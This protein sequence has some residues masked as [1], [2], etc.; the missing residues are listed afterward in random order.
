M[1]Q[2][3]NHKKI[4]GA[5][6]H[7]GLKEA[8]GRQRGDGRAFFTAQNSMLCWRPGTSDVCLVAWPDE[9]SLAKGYMTTLACNSEF[10]KMSFEQRKA[11]VFIESMHL[12]IRDKVDP[13]AVHKTLLRL[14]EYRDG[15]ADD[16]IGEF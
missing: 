9:S 2:K 6:Y 15:C 5:G 1:E 11:Q 13:M 8:T 16:M 3:T 7:A 4:F 12:I 10:H 14:E